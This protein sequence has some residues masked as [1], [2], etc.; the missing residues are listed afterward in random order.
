M[1]PY[2][3]ITGTKRNIAE[4]RRFGWRLLMT[5]DTWRMGARPAGKGM[6]YAIDNGAW[7]AFQSGRDWPESDFCGL[8][9]ELGAGADWIV[10]PDIVSGGVASLSLSLSWVDRLSGLRLLPVQD[11]MTPDDVR[12]HLSESVGI[13]L[14]G[15]CAN[16]PEKPGYCADFPNGWKIDTMRAW[17]D[18]AREAGCYF[19][20][21]R[22]NTARRIRYCQDAGADSYD[23][24]SPSIY[25]ITTRKLFYATAQGHL[26]R[27]KA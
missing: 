20:V 19:H 2:A 8:V 27:R 12:P 21:A 7:G 15:S 14:G 22:V 10:L 4:M 6:R 24:T 9:D 11:G 3:T 1:Q 25:S 26:F 13:F 5:P 18:L 17:G 23:G 16:S